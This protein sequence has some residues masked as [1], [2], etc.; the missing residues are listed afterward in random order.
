MEPA[1][2]ECQECVDGCPV[3][4]FSG[5][6]FRQDEPR[7][8]RYD[9]HKCKAYLD[10]MERT[11]GISVCGMCLYACPQGRGASGRLAA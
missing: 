5:R 4:A 1:C 6:L 10:E 8:A 2:E 3:S 7:E 9:A 11:R